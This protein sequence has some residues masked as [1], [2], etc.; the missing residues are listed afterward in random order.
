MPPTTLGFRLLS[1]LLFVFGAIACCW[2][3]ADSRTTGTGYLQGKR[4]PSVISERMLRETRSSALD[5]EVGGE[6]AGLP[7]GVVRYLTREDLKAMP[8]VSYRVTDDAHFDG[9]VQIRGVELGV[10]ARA[11]GAGGEKALIVAVCGDLYRA[12]Y[13]RAYVEAHRP[14]LVLEINGKGP[15]GWPE[16][17]GSTGLGLGPYLI[18]HRQFTPCFKILG[19]EE[20]AQIPWGVVRL[21]FRNEETVFAGITARGANA[22]DS[23]VQ[24]GYQIARQNCLRCHGPA[25]YG[26]L[27]GLLNWAGIAFFVDAS[28]KDFA[29]Y[30]RNPK[31][32]VKT[33]EMPG[34]P[35]YDDATVEALLAYFRT[36]LPKG[37]P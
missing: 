8:Q 4:E 28:P 17:K 1:F 27:K 12:H 36:F 33:A 16:R 13:P 34:N 26:R 7:A 20:E 24:A 22:S 5:L 11:L 21:E 31:T 14:V 2:A 25:S 9:A 15:A 32:V 10:L 37:K 19:N 35:G 29:A 23:A 18:S 3:F 30:V 6:L